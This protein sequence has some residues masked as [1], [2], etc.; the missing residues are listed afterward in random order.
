MNTLRLVL[1]D[2]LSR[3]IS[4]LSDID[5]SSDVVL[6]M[7]VQDETTYVQHHKQKIVLI[8]S[9]MRH[10]AESLRAEGILVD[11]IKLDDEGNTGSFTGELQRALLRHRVD[12]IVVTEAGEW[13]VSNMMRHWRELFKLPVE[14]REDTRFLCSHN[15]FAVWAKGRKEYR[16]E[17]FYRMMRRKKGW[18]MNGT[19]P[20]GG[21]WNYD[22]DNR[23]ALSKYT[24]PPLRKGFNQDSITQQVMAMVERRFSEHVGDVDSFGWAVT[25]SEALAAL[26]HFIDDCLLNFGDYQDA[27][28]QGGD[29]LFHSLLSP[30]LNI[31]LLEPEE[32]CLAV[33]NAYQKRQAPLSAVEGFIRQI[34]GW[35]EFV[36]GIYWLKMPDYTGSNYLGAERNL[37]AFYWTGDT[38][39][40]CLRE[41]ITSTL[42]FAYAHHIQRLMITGNFALLAGIAPV[43]VEEWYLSVYADAFEWVELPN[44][45]GMALYAD[46]GI[47]ASKPYAASGAYIDRMSDY[48]SECRYQAKL[49]LGADACPFTF[50]YWYFLIVNEQK[51]KKNSRMAMAYR[52]LDRFDDETKRNIVLQAEHFLKANGIS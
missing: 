24:E 19:L 18:L 21:R 1:G 36:R 4:A 44:T 37:P 25:R 14:V 11:Y 33:L 30:Y 20:E 34:L 17:F 49:K 41:C 2:Q 10:F 46:G 51:F 48:C 7:E 29:F 9:A 16:M 45:H 12:R 3:S 27:M 38:D 28:R 6:M 42:R 40:R 50:L 31:G 23:K 26:D 52:N 8:L 35:R 47:F 13:R 39:M 43:Y 32:V 5:R 22:K 15:E